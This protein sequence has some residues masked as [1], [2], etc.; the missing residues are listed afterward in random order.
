MHKEFKI[1]I[2]GLGYVGFPLAC[3][4]AKKYKVIGFDINETR[5][6]EIN[7]GFDSSNE[8]KKSVLEAALA[9][10]MVCTNNMDDIR[11]CNVY[12]VA[13]PTPVDDFY[14]P[15]LL[16][17]KKASTTVG[18]V[19]KKGDYV[20]YEST[21][22]P[23]VTEEVCAPILE[24]V[25]GLKLNE[26]FYLGYS[27]ERINP[28]DRV[29][30]VEN[31]PKITS[32][33]TPEA[34]D[35]IDNLYNSVLL[36]GTHKAPSIMVAEAAKI[37]EN[38]QRD[39]NIAFMNEIAVVFNALGIDTTDVLKAASTKWNFLNFSPGLVGGHCIS[40]D[41]YYLIQRATMRGVVPRIMIEARRLNNTM[42]NYIAER[43]VRCM[44]MHNLHALSSK[45]LILGFT[46]KENC[47]DIRN[48]KV[49]DVFNS[50]KAYT[51][52]ITIYDPWVSKEAAKHEYGMNITTDERDL[53]RGQYD[54]VI[55]C[56]KHDCFNDIEMSS[57]KKPDGIFYDVKGVLDREIITERL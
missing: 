6:D 23:G 32:G 14:N 51:S 5:I 36:K 24:K 52:D 45:M 50:L 30:T 41:P 12:V 1:G 46:F 25:S 9:N 3:L 11:E 16:P 39:V 15:E 29:H 4:F 17:L 27:P 26:D 33:S 55:Y 56:V 19:L 37:L 53:E 43:V 28:G 44:N 42:G 48:T 20:I 38:T 47:P 57:L 10:G 54:A 34:A 18:K 49:V 21:V 22:Y 31:I 8:V 40:V 35:V 13:I 7:R 2:I